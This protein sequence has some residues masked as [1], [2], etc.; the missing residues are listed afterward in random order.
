MTIVRMIIHNQNGR[1]ILHQTN[2]LP[3]PLFVAQWDSP[4]TYSELID[5]N[6]LTKWSI[7]TSRVRK[8]SIESSGLGKWSIESSRLGKWSID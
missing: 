5:P 6:M 1:V 4:V 2:V 3:I 8:C 7:E